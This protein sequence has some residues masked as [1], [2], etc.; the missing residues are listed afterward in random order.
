MLLTLFPKRCPWREMHLRKDWPSSGF[1]NGLF[2]SLYRPI[3]GHDGGWRAYEQYGDLLACL[4]LQTKFWNWLV[5][6]YMLNVET[7]L[8]SRF[9]LCVWYMRLNDMHYASYLNNSM[10]IVRLCFRSYQYEHT[11]YCLCR[12]ALHTDFL[13]YIEL[14]SRHFGKMEIYWPNRLFHHRLA[15]DLEFVLPFVRLF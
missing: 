15:N 3:V 5:V 7:M 1:P 4:K 2:C 14:F 8:G 11:D 12:R 10:A 9:C 13:N 6:C